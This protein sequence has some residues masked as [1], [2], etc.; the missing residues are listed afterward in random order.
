MGSCLVYTEIER[1]L[2]A[3]PRGEPTSLTKQ[4]CDMWCR[5]QGEL[6]TELQ[7]EVGPHLKNHQRFVTVL[8]VVCPEGFIR[9]IPK[10]TADRKL[11]GLVWRGF[12][13]QKQ[14]GTF[15]PREP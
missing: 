13:W 12:S 15:L 9:I 1:N 3:V 5:S 2:F 11:T 7:T 4:V 6:F 8:E 10:K 14:C